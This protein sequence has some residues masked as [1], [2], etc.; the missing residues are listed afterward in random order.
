MLYNEYT[1][2]D[3]FTSE[4]FWTHKY[5]T[6]KVY[7]RQIITGKECGNGNRLLAGKLRVR[8]NKKNKK[9]VTKRGVR[10]IRYQK[11]ICLACKWRQKFMMAVSYSFY[12]YIS[13]S[14]LL[15]LTNLQIDEST[16][17]VDTN[18]YVLCPYCNTHINVRKVSL[19]NWQKM[20]KDSNKCAEMCWEVSKAASSFAPKAPHVKPI[21]SAP[22][23]Q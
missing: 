11:G 8:F 14:V 13:A 10:K 9:N 17:V 22:L 16:L 18:N 5:V 19:A 1:Y 12:I 23:I 7:V 20:H 3:F 15:I 21:E 6:N 4:C 2:V